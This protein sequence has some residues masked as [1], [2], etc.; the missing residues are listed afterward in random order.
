MI[1]A[2]NP[3]DAAPIGDEGVDTPNDDSLLT[4]QPDE[5]AT[6]TESDGAETP[7][8]ESEEVEHE[9]RKYVI[10][11]ALKSALMMQA[12]YTRKTQEVAETRRA[13]EAQQAQIQ[14]QAQTQ[15][16]YLQDA[17]KIVALNEQIQQ[18]DQVD[19][20]TLNE[21]DP[22]KAQ[23]LWINYSR[24]KDA[25]NDAL[26]QLQQKEQ[27]RALQAQQE[28]AKRLEESNAALSRE[29][30]G[31]GPELAGKL[32]DFAVG[33]LGF[34]AQEMGQVTDARIV[35]L[36]HRAYLGD[37]LVSKQVAGATQKPTQV[38][39]PV[40]TVGGNAPAGKDP[41][42]MST[43]EWMRHRNEQLRKSR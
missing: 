20:N 9:G 27:Q 15:R 26:G 13:L 29:I 3:A 30:K 16:E 33:K 7:D 32:R 14:Q 17:A 21:Q 36:L 42:R 24:L 1:D 10:P 2:T 35:K 39:K 23:Q 37:Q 22:V 18:F 11:K 12:D 25:R 19:W 31:W 6:G 43:D 41:G 8:D 4:D 40:R 28:A 38:V 34:T 5:G